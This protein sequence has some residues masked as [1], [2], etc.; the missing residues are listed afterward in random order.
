MIRKKKTPDSQVTSGND[1]K[2]QD[3]FGGRQ[4][5]NSGRAAPMCSK[6]IRNHWDD[7]A[8]CVCFK[9]GATRHFKKDCPQIKSDEQGNRPRF[10]TAR[11]YTLLKADAEVSPSVVTG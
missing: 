11:V 8:V 9:C 5:D 2:S 4:S 3:P 7:Y 6:C 1:K 10:P